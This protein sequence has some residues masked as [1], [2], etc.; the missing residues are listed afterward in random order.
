MSTCEVNDPLSDTYE[1]SNCCLICHG[2]SLLLQKIGFNDDMSQ[3][4]SCDLSISWMRY[5][6][7]SEGPQEQYILLPFMLVPF[8]QCILPI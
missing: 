5:C 3:K 2:L 4:I 1:L 7:E 6:L 8:K